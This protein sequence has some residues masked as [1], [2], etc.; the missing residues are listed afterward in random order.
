MNQEIKMMPTDEYRKHYIKEYQKANAEKA[1]LA[2]AR[3]RDK[4][5]QHTRDYAKKYYAENR[6]KYISRYEENR[7]EKA[8]I[9]KEY[10]KTEK[11]RRLHQISYW[12]RRG[13]QHENYDLLYAEYV[14]STICNK[15]NEPFGER[16]DG[17]GRY[18][19]IAKSLEENSNDV[20]CCYRCMNREKF[21][22]KMNARKSA[23]NICTK[24]LKM[25]LES[26]S[27]ENEK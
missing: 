18:K 13:I 4:N 7:E 11:G 23:L 3:W 15:C 26:Q 20:V 9:S 8:K 10:H 2:K 21:M 1:K 16:G 24:P 6:E 22:T 17:S 14:A 5:R 27:Q 12:K 19:C 25:P